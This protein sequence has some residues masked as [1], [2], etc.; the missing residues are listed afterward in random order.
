MNAFVV[1]IVFR[2]G[3]RPAIVGKVDDERVIR[4]PGFL[5]LVQQDADA[6]IHAADCFVILGEVLPNF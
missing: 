2:A 5:E 4:V 3:E 1:E 6:C